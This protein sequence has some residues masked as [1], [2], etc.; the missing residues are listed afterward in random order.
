MTLEDV[1]R[2][3]PSARRNGANWMA[4]CPAHADKNPSLAISEKNGKILLNCFAGCKKDAICAAAG[5]EMRDLFLDGKTGKNGNP[6]RIVET[7]PYHDEEG[8]V[9]FEVVRLEPKD[10]RQRRPGGDGGWIWSIEGTR[11]VLYCLRGVMAADQVIITEGERDAQTAA[12]FALP[13]TYGTTNPGGAGKW[14][15]EY[16]QYL[17]AKHVV[18]IADADEP[19]RKHARQVAASVHPVAA[20]VKMLEMPGAKD[21]TEWKERGG[22]KEQLEALIKN[23]PLYSPRRVLTFHTPD[24]LAALGSIEPRYVVY[25]FG[26]RGMTTEIT[27]KPKS[28]GKTTMLLDSIR[29][30]LDGKIFLG[31][32][33]ERVP[34]VLLSEQNPASLLPALERAHLIG[35]KDL[36]IVTKL[37]LMGIPWPEVVEQTA[38]KCKQLGAGLWCTDTFSAVAGLGGEKENKSGEMYTAYSPLQEITA[39]LD[40]A[41][42]I[43][44][45]DRKIGGEVGDSGRGSSALTGAVDAVF[46]LR[47]PSGN[48]PPTMRQLDI[49][50]RYSL[51]DR[52]VMNLTE[53]GYIPCGDRADVK[54]SEAEDLILQRTPSV[55]ENAALLTAILKDNKT[56]S[57]A[58]AKRAVEKLLRSGNLKQ[59]T[60]YY[61]GRERKAYWRDE[62]AQQDLDLE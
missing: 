23:A 26:I 18:I 46:Q 45:H 49:L 51:P 7:Y 35:A 60:R 33:T 56:V 44:H 40:I 50:A 43:T 10:F 58:T 20:S 59:V 19:G 8:N 1:L 52:I 48:Q 42:V 37:D 57:D 4:L 22:R 30:I 11:R 17:R 36:H 29:C 32:A 2:R 14:K 55:K 31:H 41:T 39:L 38:E 54:L 28:S 27:G 61:A 34:V 12:L 6:G 13:L 53:D 62:T 5:M 3:F 16:N 24:E 25:P 21:L 9:L 15:N 47:R